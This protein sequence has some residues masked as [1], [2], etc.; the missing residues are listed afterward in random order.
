MGNKIYSESLEDY[1]EAIWVL[2][3]EN[4]KSIDLARHLGV[5]R[6]S[7]NKAVNHLIDNDLVDKELYGDISLTQKGKEISRKILS[8]HQL[9]KNFLVDFLN[10]DP[11]VANE[12]A[13]GIEH[14][15]SDDTAKKLSEF[16]KKIKAE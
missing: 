7:V 11:L 16:I 15:I 9:L 8:K 3:G 6:T 4:V 5:S 10:V 12:E 1:L 2:G 14:S 13:C